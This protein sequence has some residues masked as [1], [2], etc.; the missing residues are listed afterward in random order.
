MSTV[1]SLEKYIHNDLV[2]RVEELSGQDL[3]ACYQ[4]GECSAGCPAAFAMDLLPS[5]VIRL[6]QLGQVEEVLNSATIWFCAACQTCYARCP[7]GV[8]L[9]RIMEAL[10]ELAMERDGD[11]LKHT[12]IPK[13]ELEAFPQQAIIAGFRK[14]TL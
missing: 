4:C 8:D 7:K 5:Q 1:V 11:T 14:Y 10:R 6:L 12:E 3:L 2:R 13:E 9:S